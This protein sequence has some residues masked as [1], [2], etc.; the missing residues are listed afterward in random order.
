MTISSK[1]EPRDIIP[2]GWEKSVIAPYMP[3]PGTSLPS[4]SIAVVGTYAEGLN[5]PGKVTGPL[6]FPIFDYVLRQFDARLCRYENADEFVEADTSDFAGIVILIYKEALDD[7]DAVQSAEDRILTKCPEALI[8]HAARLGRTLGSKIA[9][10]QLLSQVGVPVPRMIR[11]PVCSQMVFSNHA[12]ST[13]QKV[14]LVRPGEPLDPDRYNTTYVDTTHRFNGTDYYVYLRVYAV[15]ETQ[16]ATYAGCRPTA[17]GDPSVHLSDALDP[18][19]INYFN[20]YFTIPFQ[21]EIQN[22]CSRIG[23]TLGLGFY[24]HDLLPC[25]ETGRLFVTESGVKLNPGPA[26]RQKYWHLQS[27]IP[28]FAGFFSA[29]HVLRACYAF[30]Y[31]AQR[32]GFLRGDARP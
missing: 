8:V 12:H 32:R 17:D 18:L 13:Q 31:G 6:F 15:G 26:V 23:A 11:E 14:Y 16:V 29:E 4:R 19:A 22:L 2:E 28:P 3:K 5:I 21:A 9:T 20:S 1:I 27:E 25:R 24:V 30:V 10:N 7:L